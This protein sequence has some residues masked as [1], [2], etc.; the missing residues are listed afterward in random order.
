MKKSSFLRTV[1]SLTLL[2]AMLIPV[3]AMADS[4]NYS[5]SFTYSNESE[6]PE[7]WYEKGDPEQQWV[8]TL[9]NTT[10]SNLSSKNI[11]ALTMERSDGTT[12]DRWH[13][14]S[15]YVQRYGIPYAR[16]VDS[17]DMMRLNKKRMINGTSESRLYI[18]GL[19]N[20]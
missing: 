12:V 8:V 15:N 5:F 11:L 1:I 6:H 7:S 4:P 13:T 3:T 2:V 19:Y 17:T 9:Y 14:F 10:S 16:S 20:P 18:T